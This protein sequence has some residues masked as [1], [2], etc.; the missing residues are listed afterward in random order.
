MGGGNFGSFSNKQ[1]MCMIRGK[2]G[3]FVLF[4]VKNWLFCS[5]SCQKLARYAFFVKVIIDHMK[6]RKFAQSM[7]KNFDIGGPMA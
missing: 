3:Y 4:I 2:N 7:P 6:L 1:E 5:I